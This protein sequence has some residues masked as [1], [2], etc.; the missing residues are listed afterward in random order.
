MADEHRRPHELDEADDA[1]RRA[2]QRHASER[3]FNWPPTMEELD[4]IQVLA[5]RDVPAGPSQESPRESPQKSL[6]L[7]P[8]AGDRIAWR[9]AGVPPGGDVG[10]T[11]A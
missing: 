2:E 3:A 11:A 8:N 9:A 4:S 7:A 10:D 1:T 5:M 6:Q